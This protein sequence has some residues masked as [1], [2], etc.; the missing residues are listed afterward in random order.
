MARQ[1]LLDL[2]DS[3]KTPRVPKKI[4]L[5]ARDRLRHFPAEYQLQEI[6]KKAKGVLR[7]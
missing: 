5:A 4:R 3:K 2:L 6:K 7:E 1:F